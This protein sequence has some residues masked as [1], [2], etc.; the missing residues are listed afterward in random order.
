MF[1]VLGT[2]L[3]SMV[4]RTHGTRGPRLAVVLACGFALLLPAWIA[5]SMGST[6]FNLTPFNLLSFGCVLALVIVAA[7]SLRLLP[8]GVPLVDMVVS[9]IAT[10][11]ITAERQLAKEFRFPQGDIDCVLGQI[12]AGGGASTLSLAFVAASKSHALS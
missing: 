5:L 6:L 3:A 7:T 10:S 12:E 2:L 1:L 11:P 4:A 9:A 8:G